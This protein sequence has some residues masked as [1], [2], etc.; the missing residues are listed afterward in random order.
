MFP[1]G[2]MEEGESAEEALK[3]EIQE[4]TNLTVQVHL[5]F[6]VSLIS[7][8]KPAQFAVVYL[9]SHPKGDLKLSHEHTEFKWSKWQDM[10]EE[11][12]PHPDFKKVAK[13][14]VEL[15]HKL[16]PK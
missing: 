10:K 12:L 1:G 15:Y 8:K 7:Y 13:Q 4:E 3:R 9:G 11:D 6:F 16:N 14:A 2:T 5:P